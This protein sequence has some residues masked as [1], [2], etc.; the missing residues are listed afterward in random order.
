MKL[1]CKPRK[2]DPRVP[3]MSALC[4]GRLLPD[5]P[6][7]VDYTSKL[8]GV[9]LGMMKNDMLG[10]CVEAGGYHSIQVWTANSN[11]PVDTEPD[12]NVEIVYCQAGGYNPSDPSTDQG[13]SI[14]D[15]L[16]YWVN[17]GLPV[18]PSIG[19]YGN[20]VNILNAYY[21]VDPRN[22]ADVKR[23]IADCGVALI[24]MNMPQ[25]IMSNVPDVW[26]DMIAGNGAPAGRHCV[27]LAGYDA[28]QLKLISWGRTFWMTWDF[29]GIYVDEVYG[30]VDSDWV[31]QMGLS[32]LGL[33]LGETEA[34]M[35]AS[36]IKKAA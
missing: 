31:N 32:P 24:G 23:T 26:A 12:E 13:T 7:S 18:L 20:T 33:S 10:C 27:I 34:Q 5:P 3:H 11:P 19:S 2:F 29:F 36:G 25:F 8:T 21:E 17:A 30:L 9:P 35:V 15:F 28:D 1:G 4:A 16:E 22:V 14:Q 6:D